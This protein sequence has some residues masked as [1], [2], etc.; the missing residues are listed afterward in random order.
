M[1][2]ELNKLRKK[3]DKTDKKLKKQLEKRAKLIEKTRRIKK[4]ENL[5]TEDKARE[6]EIL[7]NISTPFVKKVFKEIIR[8]SKEAQ[9]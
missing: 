4:K 9:Q 1:Q 6:T 2:K 5:P 7:K 8:L 3:I